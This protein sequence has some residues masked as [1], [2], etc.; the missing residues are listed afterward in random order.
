[1]PEGNKR[2]SP[3]FRGLR[4]VRYGNNL[5]VGLAGTHADAGVLVENL[6]AFLRSRLALELPPEAAQVKHAISPPRM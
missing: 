1:M 6:T 2:M 5:L 3:F 4:H